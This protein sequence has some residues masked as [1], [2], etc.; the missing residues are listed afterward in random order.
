MARTWPTVARMRH[1]GHLVPT[2]EPLLLHL[3]LSGLLAEPKGLT[4]AGLEAEVHKELGQVAAR[5]RTGC[6]RVHCP[7]DRKQTAQVSLGWSWKALSDPLLLN[8]HPDSGSPKPGHLG[9]DQ[10][11]QRLHA[12]PGV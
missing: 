1:T 5:S 2:L 12:A 3:Q 8:Y 10:G 4:Q 11:A 6:I 7:A 9:S